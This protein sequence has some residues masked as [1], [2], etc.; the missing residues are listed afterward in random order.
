MNAVIDA[1]KDDDVRQL[2]RKADILAG[3]EIWKTGRVLFGTFRPEKIEATVSAPNTTTRHTLLELKEEELSWRC[4]CTSNPKHFCKHVVA[5]AL[6]AQREGRGDIYK[7]AGLII[8]DRRVLAERSVGKPAFVQPGGR[9]EPGETAPQ[10][11][12]RE[13]REEFSIGVREEDLEFYGTYSAV[14]ANHPGQ[15]VHMEVFMVKAWRGEIKPDSEVEELLWLSSKLPKNVEIGSVFVHDIIP[16]LK[17][18][19]LID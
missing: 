18:E 14:A 2:A 5:T 7:A 8:Q 4:T 3:H 1:V 12:V 13:L 17:R 11:L 9:I 16:R 19:G 15:Q 10:A 6:E